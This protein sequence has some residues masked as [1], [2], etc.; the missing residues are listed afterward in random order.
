MS[1]ANRWNTRNGSIDISHTYIREDTGVS[2][3]MGI[4]FWLTYDGDAIIGFNTLDG[5]TL[6]IDL[7][8]LPIQILDS[9]TVMQLGKVDKTKIGLV[10]AYNKEFASTYET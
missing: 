2:N 8:D 4:D 5:S 6:K 10:A 9:P 1:S 7:K 3:D